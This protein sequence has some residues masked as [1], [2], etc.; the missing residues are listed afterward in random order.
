MHERFSA[1]PS[2]RLF[3]VLWLFVLVNTAATFALKGFPPFENP[4][5]L[6]PLTVSAIGSACSAP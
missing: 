6:D 2:L 5:K 1:R 3:A 4:P